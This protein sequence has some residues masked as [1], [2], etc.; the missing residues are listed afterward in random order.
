[1]TFHGLTPCRLAE[2]CS[3]LHVVI[4]TPDLNVFSTFN[5]IAK[6]ARWLSRYSYCLRAGR[7]GDRIPVGSRFSA[8]FQ[9]VPGAHPASYK[10]GTGPFTRVKRP[11][12]GVDHSPLSS[13]EVNLLKPND[14]YMSY[15]SANLQ[16]LHFKYLFNKYT[17]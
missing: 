11:G 6:W 14:I 15:R 8:P 7:S 12:R 5:K 1:M 2:E 17:Y 13:A 16:T 3:K 9:T 10:M 4:E